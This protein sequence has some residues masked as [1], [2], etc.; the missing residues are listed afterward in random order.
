MYWWSEWGYSEHIDSDI[1][2][3]DC[4]ESP[5]KLRKTRAQ[6]IKMRFVSPVLPGR[7]KEVC[8][9]FVVANIRKVTPGQC[10]P[11]KSGKKNKM[12]IGAERSVL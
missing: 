4:E 3:H 10:M 2:D 8:K 11:L 12:K 5:S 1:S 7:M 6:V 9:R